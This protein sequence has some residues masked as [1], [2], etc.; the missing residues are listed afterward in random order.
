MRLLTVEL[1]LPPPPTLPPDFLGSCGD[2]RD[3]TVAEGP[4]PLPPDLAERLPPG[5]ELLM[6]TGGLLLGS[7]R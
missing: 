4:P 7:G 5:M 3:S 1:L 6:G 2:R